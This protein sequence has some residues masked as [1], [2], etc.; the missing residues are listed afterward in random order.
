MGWDRIGSACSTWDVWPLDC[1]LL[2]CGFLAGQQCLQNTVCLQ[3]KQNGICR[4]KNATMSPHAICILVGSAEICNDMY[5]ISP[6]LRFVSYSWEDM[7]LEECLPEHWRNWQPCL[8]LLT[9]RKPVFQQFWVCNTVCDDVFHT[10][11]PPD[12][13]NDW[14]TLSRAIPVSLWLTALWPAKCKFG[15]ALLVTIPVHNSK[16]VLEFGRDYCNVP[17]DA[18]AE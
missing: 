3:I 12:W 13:H 6:S 11:G 18:C 16:S 7:T 17:A 8:I 1:L 2:R 14:P 15:Q 9:F 4:S 10:P 5:T